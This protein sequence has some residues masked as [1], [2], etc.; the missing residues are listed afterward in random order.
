MKLLTAI[1]FLASAAIAS[2][3][4]SAEKPDHTDKKVKDFDPDNVI[5]IDITP[6]VPLESSGGIAA[7]ASSGAW[8][9][10]VTNP[11]IYQAGSYVYGP[12]LE[13]LPALHQ[14]LRYRML[15][16]NGIYGTTVAI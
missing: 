15:R 16:F 7:Y 14:L 3:F 1:S 4:A 5:M 2:P 13:A 10:V 6:A 8:T 12:L 9:D 11:N